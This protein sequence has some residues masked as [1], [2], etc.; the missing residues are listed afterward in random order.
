MIDRDIVESPVTWSAKDAD[1]MVRLLR[2]LPANTGFLISHAI[3]PP[4]TPGVF[5]GFHAVVVLPGVDGKGE[6]N[7]NNAAR[8]LVKAWAMAHMDA[9]EKLGKS[10]DWYKSY[11]VA[12]A[13][14]LT[15]NGEPRA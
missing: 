4:H 5:G 3:E 1:E 15:A 10:D 2:A 9:A 13:A 6:A 12:L 7:E 14:Q 11:V 8:A